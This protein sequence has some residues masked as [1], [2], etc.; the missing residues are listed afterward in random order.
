MALRT[1]SVQPRFATRPVLHGT[2]GMV[3][4]GHY[5]AAAIGLRVLEQGGNAVDAGVAAGFALA[6]LKPQENGLG[7]EAPI[8]I[9]LAAQGRTV[10][11]NGQGWAPQRASIAWFREQ[12]I[13]AIPPNG[14]LPATVPGAFGSWCAALLRFGTA[15]LGD[16]L[17]PAVEL[18]EGGFP[19]DAALRTRIAGLADRFR[20]EWPSSAAIYL[21]GDQVPSEG[22][23]LRN[24]DW[25]MTMKG[26]LDAAA[27][28]SGRGREASIQAAIDYFY[29]GPVAERAVAFTT[30]HAVR[31]ATGRAHRALFTVKDWAA[32]GEHGT[33]LEAPT[34][35]TYRGVV[36]LKCGTWTQGPVLLQQLKLLE[37][38]DIAAL[39][40]NTT[41]YLHLLLEVAKL[42]FTDREQYYGDP[43]FTDVPLA[44]I[45]SDAYTAERRR[46]VDPQR[47]SLEWR[48]GDAAHLSLSLPRA[49]ARLGGDQPA[50]ALG[51]QTGETVRTGD[52]EQVGDT[53][54]VDVVDRWGNL[55]SAT[56]SGGWIPSSPVVEGLGFPLGT[57]GQIFVLDER[58]A[59]ALAPGKRP[60]TTL[61]PSLAL[62]QGQP[63]LAFGTPGGDMQDQWS[64]QFFLNVVDFG[65]DL[66]AA[67][68]APT[69]HTTHFPSSFYPHAAY[70]GRVHVERRVPLDVRE[71]LGALGHEVQV[72]D[73]WSHGQPTAVAFEPRRGVVAGAASARSLLPYVMG[74]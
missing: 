28:E 68:D 20:Q 24:A 7:G 40:H 36:V 14:F 65:L 52:D 2:L 53:T 27:R 54:H 48:P 59:N 42:V 13:S 37:T 46:L 57:R 60:R 11:I 73:D 23:L 3:A 33:R 44:V 22:S 10:A 8:L 51:V 41:A 6:V 30:A 38:Y 32:Y 1:G 34:R 35:V 26:A 18:A 29:K 15:S 25:A 62:R 49:A 45:L 31:D 58:H 70:P 69:V 21:P 55:F 72:D 56:P 5:L 63:W 19:L 43:E 9:H 39:G 67:L 12:G 16:I 61:T 66:Q 47:A 50:G 4:A 64:L 71:A 74:R 17:G